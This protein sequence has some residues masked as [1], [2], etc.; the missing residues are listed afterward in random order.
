MISLNHQITSVLQE[1]TLNT[2]KVC[3]CVCVCVCACVHACVC[4]RACA[5]VCVASTEWNN[6]IYG[7]Y[8]FYSDIQILLALVFTHVHVLSTLITSNCSFSCISL[9]LAESFNSLPSDVTQLLALSLMVQANGSKC[10][11]T[12][13]ISF[14][15]G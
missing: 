4:V 8:S 7:L 3:V 14:F 15:I 5:R 12:Q 10:S 6:R 9:L 13:P 11:I 1:E 2:I